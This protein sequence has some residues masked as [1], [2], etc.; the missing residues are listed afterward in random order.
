MIYWY[1]DKPNVLVPLR[2]DIRELPA[3]DEFNGLRN[4]GVILNIKINISDQQDQSCVEELGQEDFHDSWAVLVRQ[5]DVFLERR[6]DWMIII[7]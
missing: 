2:V 7:L 4:V 3:E 6:K 1:N 5:K